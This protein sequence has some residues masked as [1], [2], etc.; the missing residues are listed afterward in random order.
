MPLL[1]FPSETWA[2]LKAHE[3]KIKVIQAALKRRLVGLTLWNQWRLNL[4]NEDVR[5]RSRVK[6]MVHVDEAKHNWADHVMSRR[7]DRWSAATQR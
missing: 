5:S 6:D 7:E 1:I 3:N 4:H 2:L